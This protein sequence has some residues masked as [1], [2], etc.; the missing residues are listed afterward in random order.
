MSVL[1]IAVGGITGAAI[2]WLVGDEELT[3]FGANA[4]GSFVGLLAGA[5]AGYLF[6]GGWRWIQKRN[7][8]P[9]GD[10]I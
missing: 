4:G 9:T 3:H 7:G 6:A 1:T 8:K 10:D 5:A 2:G